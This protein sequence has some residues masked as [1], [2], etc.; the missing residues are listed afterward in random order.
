MYVY[1]YIYI[2]LKGT[3]L[4][5]G[6]PFVRDFPSQG[7]SLGVSPAESRMPWRPAEMLRSHFQ[8]IY[9]YIYI[10][11]CIMTTFACSIMP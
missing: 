1:I 8:H 3:S 10:Y 7:I 6:L 11:I 9:I 5:K 2:S 4:Y